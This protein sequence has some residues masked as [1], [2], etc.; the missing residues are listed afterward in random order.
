MTS[1]LQR[2]TS[3]IRKPD[4]DSANSA[5]RLPKAP[6]GTNGTPGRERALETSRGNTEANGTNGTNGTGGI[7][8][9]PCPGS[10]AERVT[11]M[12][13][14][15]TALLEAEAAALAEH[16]LLS[17]H[18]LA[19]AHVAAITA[20]LDRLPPPSSRDGEKLLKVTRAFLGSHWHLDAIRHGWP[21]HELFGVHPVAPSVRVECWGLIP[22]LSIG[23]HLGAKLES[24]DDSG[25]LVT[26]RSGTRVRLRRFNPG[27]DAA[28]P[29]WDCP[30]VVPVGEAA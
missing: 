24:L 10:I 15:G 4:A 23:P 17:W 18:A 2:M 19:D 12:E 11:I 22:Q 6:I 27:L 16:G 25:A 13:V 1:W 21:Q 20:E 29:W 28:V 9:P 26:Y 7:V 5:V 8:R 30:S 3:Q 14:N